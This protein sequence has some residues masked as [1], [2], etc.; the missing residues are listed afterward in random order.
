VIDRLVSWAKGRVPELIALVAIL[1]VGIWT[2]NRLGAFDLMTTVVVNGANLS[3]PNLFSTVDHPFHATR[4]FALLESLKDGH[5]LRWVGNHQGGYPVEFYPLGVA[6]FEVG[7]WTLLLGSVQI[8]AVHKLAV[9]L[10]FLLPAIGF[11]VLARVDRVSPGVAIL[12]TAMQVAI[13]GGQGLTSWTTG[14][15]TELVQ[16]GL[17][18][19]VAGATCAMIATALLIG[20]VRH[21]GRGSAVGAVLAAAS[22]AYCNPRSLFAIAI[23]AVAILLVSLMPDR[24]PSL[25]VRATLQRIAV[26]GIGALLL[27][28]PIVVPLLRYSDLYYFVHY[29]SYANTGEFWTATLHAVSPVMVYACLVGVLVA[30]I[31]PHLFA[32]R[33][34]AVTLIAYML[35]TIWLSTSTGADLIQQLEPPRLMPFQRQLMLY[36]AAFAIWWL[37]SQLIAA[38]AT[39]PSLRLDARRVV[40]ASEVVF[41]VV[42]AAIVLIVYVKPVSGVGELYQ[43]LVP[44]TTSGTT[45]YAEYTQA[46]DVADEALLDGTAM[47]VLGTIPSGW[48]WH[49]N[50]FAPTETDAPVFYNDWLWGWNKL[51][52]GT[53]GYNYLNGNSYPDPGSA[54]DA[55]YLQHNGIG[56]V[57]V[58]DVATADPA[59]NPRVVARTS[60][61][62]TFVQTVGIWD[63]Y[64][65]TT[66]TAIVTDGGIAPTEISVADERITATFAEGSGDVVIRRNWFPRWEATVDGEAVPITRTDDGYMQI[67]VPEGATTIELTYRV[68]TVDWLDRIG[69]L[70]GVLLVVIVALGRGDRVRSTWATIAALPTRQSESRAVG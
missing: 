14:G 21:G 27:A 53:P 64:A 7:I 47:L 24:G 50:L 45:G 43:G 15:Y 40:P 19:N 46:V 54:L 68:T 35:L 18:T 33:A 11:W 65:V 42:V 10:I 17:V 67:T 34:V 39:S 6:W 9:I 41:S 28:L 62:L 3:V 16:W 60:P 38:L 1:I 49:A 63:V 29:Q 5:L 52:T 8:L 66:P 55:S 70:I 69:A 2:A 25:P 30:I 58:T 22:A 31:V 23:A 4:A 13:P 12:A 44:T 56:V 26:V 37:G 36:L 32:V 20:F 48:E 51:Q 59:Q 61:A 57:L